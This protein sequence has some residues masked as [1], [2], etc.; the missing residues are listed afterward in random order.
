MICGPCTA[1]VTNASV[2]PATKYYLQGSSVA[3]KRTVGAVTLFVKE[4]L[5]LRKRIRV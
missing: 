1:G 2:P 3:A 4:M 5:I